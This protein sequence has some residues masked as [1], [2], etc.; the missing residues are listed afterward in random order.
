MHDPNLTT[1]VPVDGLGTEY[2]NKHNIA[3]FAINKFGESSIEMMTSFKM[4]DQISWHFTGKYGQDTV[5][6][7]PEV[8]K[9]TQPFQYKPD[10]LFTHN[11]A[12][13]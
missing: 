9:C 5:I 12:L 10:K 2:K 1:T 13:T 3:S 4:T 8:E 11:R 7:L 6:Y